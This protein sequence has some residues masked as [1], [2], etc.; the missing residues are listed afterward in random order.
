MLNKRSIVAW[1]IVLL[2][3]FLAS[4]S[5]PTPPLTYSDAQLQKIEVSESG[6]QALRDRMDELESLIQKGEW[7]NIRT[8]IHGPLGDL[9]SKTNYLTQSLLL[10]RDKTPVLNAAKKI[11]DDLEDIDTAATEGNKKQAL[12]EYKKAITDFDTFLDLVPKNS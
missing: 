12:S 6:I 3:A 2:V 10:P 1:V 8:F 7:V 11:F 9:R 4:C 5:S